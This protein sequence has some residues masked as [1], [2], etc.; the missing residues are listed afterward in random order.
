M[1]IDFSNLGG[2]GGGGQYVLPVASQST[3]GGVKIG[4]GVNIDS[5]GTISVSG[6]DV[7]NY[8][9]ALKNINE[10]EENNFKVI[11][12]NGWLYYVEDDKNTEE[13]IFVNVRLDT[14][15]VNIDMNIDGQTDTDIVEFNSVTISIDSEGNLFYVNEN[16][17]DVYYSIKTTEYQYGDFTFTWI[18]N[19]THIEFPQQAQMIEPTPQTDNYEYWYC[20]GREIY[21]ANQNALGLVKIGEGIDLAEDGTISVQGEATIVK[22]L[23]EAPTGLTGGDIYNMATDHY[24]PKCKV[25]DKDHNVLDIGS[26][27]MD[28]Y[29]PLTFESDLNTDALIWHCAHWDYQLYIYGGNDENGDFCYD[30]VLTSSNVFVESGSVTDVNTSATIEFS[31]VN[32]TIELVNNGQGGLEMTKTGDNFG[33]FVH[34][35]QDEKVEYLNDGSFIVKTEGERAKLEQWTDGK[36]CKTVLLYYGELPTNTILLKSTNVYDEMTTYFSWDG[37]KLCSWNDEY[38]QSRGIYDFDFNAEKGF[39][40]D[41]YRFYEGILSITSRVDINSSKWEL[42]GN[43]YKYSSQTNEPLDW[44]SKC[45]NI[46]QFGYPLAACSF[47]DSVTFLGTND[48]WINGVPSDGS[49]GQVLRRTS[50]G[51]GWESLV[52]PKTEI[53]QALPYGGN[54]GDLVLTNTEYYPYTAATFISMNSTSE[55]DKNN[56]S[57]DNEIGWYDWGNNYIYFG[58]AS[59]YTNTKDT[60]LYKIALRTNENGDWSTSNIAYI[61]VVKVD[62][63]YDIIMDEFNYYD[64]GGTPVPY[65]FWLTLTPTGTTSANTPY[66]PL[67][68]YW[69]GGYGYK[70][71]FELDQDNNLK[72]WMRNSDADRDSQD[73]AY[74]EG[75]AYGGI[76]FKCMDH[77][78]VFYDYINFDQDNTHLSIYKG[79][80]WYELGYLT[81]PE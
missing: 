63:G 42:V 39:G 37:E 28:D 41:L 20:V 75:Q 5:A 19:G 80:V 3:L 54:E 7:A 23:E 30:Y 74:V 55:S 12:N 36:G 66:L 62:G 56:F 13:N 68:K 77:T 76:G 49:A 64:T 26:Y 18:G 15:Y 58:N 69:D 11:N 22:S 40:Y 17:E 34:R 38:M 9:M 21:I 61:N 10:G 16:D 47:N 1:I 24:T 8:A 60:F 51:Y 59:A 27:G 72:M 52:I 67:W 57:N 70:F 44:Q 29:Q 79:G 33:F 4:S 53:Y 46:R 45:D 6:S 50:E 71:H 14:D 73:P 43:W 81:R 31:G 25:Y 78:T 65:T 32:V 48:I 35:N 2:G